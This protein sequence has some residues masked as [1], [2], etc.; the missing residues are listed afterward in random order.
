MCEG[1]A[2][3]DVVQQPGHFAAEVGVVVH[4]L[5]L[6]DYHVALIIGDGAGEDVPFAG[7]HLGG[8]GVDEL[9]R[10]RGGSVSQGS[11]GNQAFLQAE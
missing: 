7:N 2:S 1:L 8:G 6:G 4:G 5:A 11:Q 3:L 9:L 10:A